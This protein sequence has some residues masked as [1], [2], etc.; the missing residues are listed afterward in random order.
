M[1]S[2]L[3]R[4]FALL[5]TIATG[6]AIV[7]AV[8]ADILELDPAWNMSAVADAARDFLRQHGPLAAV[9]LLYLEESGVPM[10][11]PGDFFVMYLGHREAG[12]WMSDIFGLAG[13]DHSGGARFH[14]SLLD[15]Q[16]L[17][18]PAGSGTGG[19]HDAPNARSH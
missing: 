14:Q 2:L 8:E 5:L 3:G 4:H 9:G 7:F 1:K 17:G 10:P 15:L 18:A 13:S 12:D 19:R 16:T 11:V 6:V